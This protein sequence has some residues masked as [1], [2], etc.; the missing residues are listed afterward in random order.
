MVPEFVKSIEIFI[1]NV[2]KKL[3]DNN[4]KETISFPFKRT[5]IFNGKQVPLGMVIIDYENLKVFIYETFCNAKDT[6]ICIPD[7]YIIKFK[8]LLNCT[9]E[10]RRYDTD[11]KIEI[12][13]KNCSFIK[14]SFSSVIDE[15]TMK[16]IY[17]SINNIISK[18]RIR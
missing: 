8:D 14:L 2:N 18:N 3:K 5:V 1:S 15:Q 11:L 17:T 9:F 6:L 7:I 4:I 12:N 10:D 13:N 16:N